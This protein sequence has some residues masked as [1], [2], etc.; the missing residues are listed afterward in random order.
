[1]HELSIASAL[2]EKVLGFAQEQ[3]ATRVLSVRLA[4]GELTHLQPDQLRFCYEAITKNTPI[5]DSALEIEEVQALVR[6]GHCGYEGTPRYW[7][8]ALALVAVPTLQCP[9]C[10]ELVEAIQGHECAIK[11]V[12]FARADE[13]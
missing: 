5:E 3:Q 1:M 12:K 11:A 2:M 8:E 4:L 6:C 10:S 9:E 7:D 13:T